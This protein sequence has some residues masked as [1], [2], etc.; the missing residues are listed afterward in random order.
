MSS[1][2]AARTARSYA[3]NH[4]SEQNECFPKKHCLFKKNYIHEQHCPGI[5]DLSNN[6]IPINKV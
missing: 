3:E 4:L 1:P 5:P 6:S 2:S